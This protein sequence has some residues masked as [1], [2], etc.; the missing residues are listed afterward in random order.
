MSVD[1]FTTLTASSSAN[2]LSSEFELSL[3]STKDQTAK[4][5]TNN[6]VLVLQRMENLKR[7]KINFQ[8][9]DDV[10]ENEKLYYGIDSEGNSV[11]PLLSPLNKKE[12]LGLCKL[13]V[14]HFIILV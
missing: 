9:F 4:S 1:R 2:N 8:L 5:L 7:Y 11:I 6:K 14:T 10:D 3:K 12:N 13:D